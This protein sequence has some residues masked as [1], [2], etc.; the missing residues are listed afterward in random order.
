MSDLTKGRLMDGTRWRI[1]HPSNLGGQHTNG[2]LP[3]VELRSDHWSL[4]IDSGLRSI[5]ST[6]E[7]IFS[8]QMWAEVPV[9]V[10]STRIVP[11]V[12][13]SGE[14]LL[15]MRA[16]ICEL[17]N[18]GHPLFRHLRDDGAAGTIF[19]GGIP[20]GADL[21]HDGRDID[22]YVVLSAY[23]HR[24]ITAAALVVGDEGVEPLHQDL[25]EAIVKVWAGLRDGA[26]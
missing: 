2:R 25:A 18:E 11:D 20:E 24:S 22:G 12:L 21:Q 16:L 4:I 3:L 13:A 14:T 10:E 23:K 6:A 5:L 19:V 1:F 26:A 17:E 9:A 15:E 7:A 8:C